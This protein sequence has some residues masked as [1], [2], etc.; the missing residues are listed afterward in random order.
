MQ[1]V[2]FQRDEHG[3]WNEVEEFVNVYRNDVPEELAAELCSLY[4]L[5]RIPYSVLLLEI[6]QTYE[7]LSW[8]RRLVTPEIAAYIE[9]YFVLPAIAGAAGT[10]VDEGD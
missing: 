10:A 2:G 1:L 6:D 4:L 9:E 5:L 7:D 3:G 8:K